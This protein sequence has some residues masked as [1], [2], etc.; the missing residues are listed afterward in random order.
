MTQSDYGDGTYSNKRIRLRS[1]VYASAV[2]VLLL[3]LILSVALY[4]MSTRMHDDAK[5]VRLGMKS[6][7]DAQAIKIHLLEFSRLNTIYDLTRDPLYLDRI[8][9]ERSAIDDWV[10]QIKGIENTQ[11]DIVVLHSAEQAISA[12][13]KTEI[14]SMEKSL[15]RR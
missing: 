15:S 4:L 13:W 5:R 12:I 10:K 9:S 14:D 8:S 11:N 6:V 7:R 2:L 1:S 3:F